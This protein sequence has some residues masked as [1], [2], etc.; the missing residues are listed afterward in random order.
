MSIDAREKYIHRIFIG[1]VLLKALNGVLEIVGGVLLLFTGAFVQIVEILIRNEL[2]E[3][4][5]D[6]V[7]T[8]IQ[9]YL[10]LFTGHAQLFAAVYL[11]SHG[12]IKIV[13]VAGLLRNKLWAY[14]AAI[15]VFILFIVYQMYRF[16]FTHSI[17]L[18]LFTIFDIFV[19]ALTWHEYKY[20]KKH[21]SFPH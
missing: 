10:P 4:P 11:L 5:A 16:T 19:I 21:H 8:H 17:F 18:I 13:L 9:H 20:F 6:F 1:G 12:V 15:V 14:P 7:A 2:I 3:D